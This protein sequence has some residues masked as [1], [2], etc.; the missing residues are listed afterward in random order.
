MKQRDGASADGRIADVGYPT[1][2]GTHRSVRASTRAGAARFR[3]RRSAGCA[4]PRDRR[5]RK[6]RTR[7]CLRE[8]G[9]E[10]EAERRKYARTSSATR[11][12]GGLDQPAPHSRGVAGRSRWLDPPPRFG[13]SP[14]GVRAS[15]SRLHLRDRVCGCAGDYLRSYQQAH[16]DW[17]F[18][19]PDPDANLEQTSRRSTAAADRDAALD[20]PLGSSRGHRASQPIPSGAG[21]GGYAGTDG[22]LRRHRQLH[23]SSRVELQRYAARRS[24]RTCCRRIASAFD[25][26]GS[27]KPALTNQFERPRPPHSRARA[28]PPA[29]RRLRT[30]PRWSTS[31]SSSRRAWSTPGNRIEDAKRMLRRQRGLRRSAATT[32]RP[33]SSRRV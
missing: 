3:P 26:S 4:L 1:S 10:R 24:A 8:P 20:P 15:G 23:L 11:S 31:A 18:V 17:V 19:F 2:C 27:S 5:H 12:G 9:L 33:S 13:G 32:S 14:H 25:I 16:P 22:R 6:R 30:S 29:A 7:V 21:S 28:R